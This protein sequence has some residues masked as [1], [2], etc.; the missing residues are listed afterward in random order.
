M[1]PDGLRFYDEFVRHKILDT[2]GDFSL[3]GYPILG[4][5]RTYKS[6]HDINHLMVE[7]ILASPDNWQLVEFNEDDLRL[8]KHSAINEGV[9]GTLAYNEA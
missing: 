8:A 4:H 6:G 1:N 9:Q 7:T 2:I 3:I 5:I